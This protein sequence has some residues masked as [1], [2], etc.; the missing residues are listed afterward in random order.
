ML[1]TKA[2]GFSIVLWAKT[3]GFVGTQRARYQ[4]I[5][6]GTS[7]H[8]YR[9]MKIRCWDFTFDL[10]SIKVVLNWASRKHC[11]HWLWAQCVQFH[12]KKIPLSLSSAAVSQTISWW[13]LQP[14]PCCAQVLYA[15]LGEWH[16][17][18]CLQWDKVPPWGS[19]EVL[20]FFSIF[21]F[22][23]FSSLAFITVA[24]TWNDR[25]MSLIAE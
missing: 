10:P 12:N 23:Y 24:C 15:H 19:L 21:I 4:I 5:N 18:I 20:S 1:E 22:L 25:G 14:W 13:P 6:W 8:S 3:L 9:Y 17:S 7:K 2:W 16:D 11:W